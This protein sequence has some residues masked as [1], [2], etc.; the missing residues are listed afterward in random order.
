MRHLIFHRRNTQVA[1]PQLLRLSN[2][3]EG[4]DC[5]GVF[6]EPP[7]SQAG[8]LKYGLSYPLQQYTQSPIIRTG[9]ISSGAEFLGKFKNRALGSSNL[10]TTTKN[11]RTATAQIF[12][13]KN[14]VCNFTFFQYYLSLVCKFNFFFIFIL[15][16]STLSVEPNFVTIVAFLAKLAK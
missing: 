10:R 1:E 9:R 6:S 16:C 11:L 12:K 7:N 15:Q 2:P 14:Q 13:A 5:P 8:R 4:A 3:G